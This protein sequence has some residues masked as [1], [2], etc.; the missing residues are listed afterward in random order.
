MTATEPAAATASHPFAAALAARDIDALVAALA[1]DAV[2]H[3]AITNTPFEG[4][5]VLADLYSSLFEA[6][7]ELRVTDEFHNGDTHVF[8]WE[9]RMDGRY[10]AG[11]DRLRL[12]DDGK[13]RDITIVGRPL[14]G[15]ATFLTGLGFHF[16][17][18]RRGRVVARLLRVT[19]L[20][21]AP[22][23]SLVDAIVRWLVSGSRRP[24]GRRTLS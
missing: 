20:P 3:S 4:R 1:P 2:L 5:E 14:T 9:G 12:D 23:F 24:A 16:A 17:R 15:L 8:F 6:F 18:R 7:E 21:L 10:V 22:M 19:A 11:A 13:V